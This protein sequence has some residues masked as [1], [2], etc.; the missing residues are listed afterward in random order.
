MLTASHN[1]GTATVTNKVARRGERANNRTPTLSGRLPLV[2][3]NVM[4]PTKM[5]VAVTLTPN[6][7]G[8]IYTASCTHQHT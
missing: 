7:N 2:V 1:G 4:K 5:S 8:H 6:I 3:D